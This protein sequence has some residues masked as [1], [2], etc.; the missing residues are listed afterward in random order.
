MGVGD[1]DTGIGAGDVIA[2]GS[3][4]GHLR[5]YLPPTYREE[6]LDL[7]LKHRDFGENKNAYA[8]YIA[9]RFFADRRGAMRESSLIVS[10]MS[11]IK[12]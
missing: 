7:L 3:S 10:G 12:D 5:L 4:K 1:R 2:L 9:R 8:A 11:S 6:A